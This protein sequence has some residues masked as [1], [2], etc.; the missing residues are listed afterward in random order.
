MKTEKKIVGYCAVDSGQILIVDPC[1][2]SN[3]KDGEAFPINKKD[4]NS[5]AQA[6]KITTNKEGVGE[7]LVS[8]VGGTGVVSSS[9]YGDGNYPVVATIVDEGKFGKRIKKLEIKF[10]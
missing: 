3:W 2:L 7:M 9:G 5:Y 1:Y 8:G 6:C 10:F 4:N